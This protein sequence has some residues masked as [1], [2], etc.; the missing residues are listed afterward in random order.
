MTIDPKEKQL[1]A[2]RRLLALKTAHDDLL[3]YIRLQFPDPNDTDDV[4]KSRYVTTPLALILCQIIEKVDRGEYKRV[5]LSVGPQLGKSEITSRQGPAWLMGRDPHRNIMVGGYNQDFVN[6]N[7]GEPVRNALR[8]RLHSQVFSGFELKTYAVDHQVTV[9]GGQLNFIGVGG[10]GTGKPADVFIVDDPIRND[11]DAQSAAYRE[12]LWKWFNA[13]VFSRGHDGTAVIVV[14]TRWHQDDLIGRLCDPD[15]PER[16]GK[17]A[18]IADDWVYINLPAVVKDPKLAESLGLTLEVPADEKVVQQFGSV[19]MSSIWPG[20]KSLPLLAE[21]RRQDA[22]IFGALYMGEPTP[23]DGETFKIQDMVEYDVGDLPKKLQFYGASDHAVSTKQM[24]DKTVLGCVGVDESDDIWVMPD[25]KWDRIE[26]DVTVE[27]MILQ[28]QRHEPNLW[29]MESELISKSFGPFL[30]KRMREDRVYTYLKPV[31]PSKDKLTRARAIQGRMQM[32]K[33][34]F[35]RFATWWPDAK[36]Q[37]LKFPF[38]THDDFVDWLSHIGLGLNTMLK[39]ERRQ[40]ANDNHA[41][42]SGSIEW[43]LNRT[44]IEGLAKA[45]ETANGGW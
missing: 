4:T 30:R 43:I 2:A 7:F 21:A 32:R 31:T 6:S 25:I 14:H 18:G 5:A 41:P 36:A 17:Y 44:R 20:R 33:V 23:E 35:P 39:A 13:V 26:T 22:R 10:S 40:M 15:H 19:P 8:S 16:N 3:A 28:M 27:E 9:Q 45:R 42:R 29:W 11:D 38:G 34:H 37:M 12:R 1:K 24:A